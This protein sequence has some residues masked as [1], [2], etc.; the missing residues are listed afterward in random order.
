MKSILAPA[1][2]AAAA[3]ASSGTL[4]L[5]EL[6]VGGIASG[7]AEADVV[8]QLGEPIRRVE[9]GEGTE[10]HYPGLV[11]T[12][13]WLEQQASG[14]DRRVVALLGTD[15]H[16][17]TPRGLCPGMPVEAANRL[18]GSPVVAQRETGDFLE[19]YPKAPGCWLQL[20]VA[21]GII[22]SVAVA[23]QP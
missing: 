12:E 19:Y 23:C 15:P 20:S 8:R 2:L 10:L 6:Q 13:A 1:F 7:A 3:V 11:V 18:Y 4:P 5:S 21:S 17:C 14:G 16:A 22:K 9:T